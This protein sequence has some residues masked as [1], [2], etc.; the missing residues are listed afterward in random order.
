MHRNMHMYR[1]NIT[2]IAG[3]GKSLQCYKLKQAIFQ[4]VL[5]ITNGAFVS[6]V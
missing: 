1:W 6:L 3:G 2:F 5:L 4:D